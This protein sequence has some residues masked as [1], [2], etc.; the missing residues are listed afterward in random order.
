MN[1]SGMTRGLSHSYQIELVQYP[2]NISRPRARHEG[3]CVCLRFGF[4]LLMFLPNPM[5]S[6]LPLTLC[7]SS[8]SCVCVCVAQW[9][10]VVTIT[11]L[12]PASH[13]SR[14]PVVTRETA[15]CPGWRQPS[16]RADQY[17]SISCPFTQVTHSPH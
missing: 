6:S 8:N 5:F 14:P 4:E 1:F 9:L 17:C 10:L 15:G 16:R 13:P 7:P 11:P 2:A 3:K 12:R